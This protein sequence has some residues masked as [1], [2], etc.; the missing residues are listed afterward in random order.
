[1]RWVI[2]LLAFFSEPKLYP[3]DLWSLG[4]LLPQGPPELLSTPIS[5]NSITFVGLRCNSMPVIAVDAVVIL[6][7][8]IQFCSVV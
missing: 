5:V 6:R 2:V 3:K 1:M 7:P 8:Q 4:L